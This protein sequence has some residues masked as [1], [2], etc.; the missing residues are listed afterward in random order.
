MLERKI[1]NQSVSVLGVIA[2]A[3]TVNLADL[4]K[5]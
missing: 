5:K 4:L 2:D 1:C 3:L